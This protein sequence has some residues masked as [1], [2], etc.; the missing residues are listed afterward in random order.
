[1]TTFLHF[2][3]YFTSEHVETARKNRDR[4]RRRTPFAAA[5]DLLLNG[6]VPPDTPGAIQW[7]GLRYRFDDNLDAGEQAVIDLQNSVGFHL[8]SNANV[9][10]ALALHIALGQCAE[11]VR[12]HP[13]WTPDSQAA[14]LQRYAA[15]ADAFDRIE[16]PVRIVEQVWRGLA[17]VV[18]GIVL[19]DESRL[20][21]GA[22]V[23][24]QVID[25]EIRPEGYLPAA[26]EGGDGSSLY[27]QLFSVSGLVLMADAASHV[28][29]D[30]WGY[31]SRGIS[32]VTAAS[33]LI[34]YYYYPDQWRWDAVAESEATPLFREHGAFLEMVNRHAHPKD[35][36]LLLDDLRPLYNLT[37][38]GLTTLSHALPARR[39]LF[40]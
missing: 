33:Y 31:T 10:D 39:G 13:A 34:Y 6:N 24:R 37:G 38:G 7:N 28:S 2:G 14:W 18:S 15:Q 8:D 5:W 3:L 4:D 29:L 11:L 26:V 35:L 9:F 12:D 32:A 17:N 25:S 19:E 20:Q 16:D 1:M 22:A 27:R 23:Y 40:G 21:T 30:L 36:T